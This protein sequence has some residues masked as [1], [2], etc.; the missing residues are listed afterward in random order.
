MEM[1]TTAISKNHSFRTKFI[2]Q[3]NKRFIALKN[4]FL[5]YAKY[6]A[7]LQYPLNIKLLAQFGLDV[8]SDLRIKI[9]SISHFWKGNFCRPQN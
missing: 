2:I 1:A 4:N 3:E 5:P 8:N 6:Q 7:L 9:V